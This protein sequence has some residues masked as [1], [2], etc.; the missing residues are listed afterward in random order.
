MYLYIFIYD[1]FTDILI[2]I[3]YLWYTP[4]KF[5]SQRFLNVFKQRKKN[6]FAWEENKIVAMKILGKEQCSI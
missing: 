3:Y 4:N 5:A 6:L 1:L 2:N